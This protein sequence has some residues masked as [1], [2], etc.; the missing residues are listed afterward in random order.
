[1]D[2][3]EGGWRTELEGRAAALPVPPRP[4]RTWRKQASQRGSWFFNQEVLGSTPGRPTGRRLPRQTTTQGP[5]PV[6]C[7]PSPPGPP[8]LPPRRTR[9]EHPHHPCALMSTPRTSTHPCVEV[10]AVFAAVGRMASRSPDMMAALRR[11]KA[12]MERLD[13]SLTS[14]SGWRGARRTSHQDGL[15]GTWIT[16]I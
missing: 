8:D 12:E 10:P 1:M 16:G 15:P 4:R 11:L 14:E 2:V 5:L 7:Q 3:G 9:P 13:V 6:A